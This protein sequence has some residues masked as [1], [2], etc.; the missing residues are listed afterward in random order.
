MIHEER[1]ARSRLDR[2][3]DPVPVMCA[4]REDAKDEEV[5]RSLK[6]RVSIG[7]VFGRHSTRL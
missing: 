6:Q 4:K 3:R 5:E 7:L 1:V 2:H